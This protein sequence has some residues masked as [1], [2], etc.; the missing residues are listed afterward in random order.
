M[1]T[2]ILP[3]CGFWVQATFSK[4][5]GLCTECPA[6]PSDCIKTKLWSSCRHPSEAVT[7]AGQAC[8]SIHCRSSIDNGL[9]SFADARC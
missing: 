2:F 6:F 4:Q 9:F 1:C 5:A 8:A 3:A 7:S